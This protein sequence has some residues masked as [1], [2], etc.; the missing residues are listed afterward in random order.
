VDSAA[1]PAS[2]PPHLVCERLPKTSISSNFISSSFITPTP[3]TS[4]P[5]SFRFIRYNKHTTHFLK[6]VLSR[7][8]GESCRMGASK[9]REIHERIYVANEPMRD[10][11]TSSVRISYIS[12]SLIVHFRHRS[13]GVQESWSQTPALSLTV[14]QGP[15]HRT[16]FTQSCMRATL[17]STYAVFPHSDEVESRSQDHGPSL[18]GPKKKKKGFP[19]FSFF[20]SVCCCCCFIAT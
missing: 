6:F 14:D 1:E 15:R 4:S 8:A 2:S 7:A 13:E 11:R 12:G 9:G 16:P 10:F 17:E 19:F 5:P 20:L 3:S 18:R